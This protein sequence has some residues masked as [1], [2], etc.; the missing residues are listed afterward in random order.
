MQTYARIAAGIV[1][2]I[3]MIDPEGPPL[4]ERFHADIVAAMMPVPEG[5]GIVEGWSWDGEAFAAPP[6]LEALEA[7]IPSVTARQLR[8]WLLGQG[9]TL[10]QVDAAIDALP[11]EQRPAAAIEWEY[12]T[13]YERSHPLIE[14][15][16]A[17]LG[18]SS[19]EIDAGFRAAATL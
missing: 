9:R 10:A 6:T 8:L 14:P 7:P 13:S 5:L 18:F 12:A 1:A 2:E 16:G 3:I 11:V 4:A 17:A 19:A 15:L